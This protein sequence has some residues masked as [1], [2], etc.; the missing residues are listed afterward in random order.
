MLKYYIRF[1]QTSRAVTRHTDN[2]A[3]VTA[4]CNSGAPAFARARLQPEVFKTVDGKVI[5]EDELLHFLAMKIKTLSQDE[6]VL[7]AANCFDSEWIG[8][9]KKTLFELQR[10]AERC[11]Q[12]KKLP[13]K[14]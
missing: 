11:G 10:C 14:C 3:D 1:I 12:H 7:L 9:S 2:M 13:L 5:V 8:A 6:I 4:A